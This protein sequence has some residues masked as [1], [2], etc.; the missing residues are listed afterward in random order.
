MEYN[1]CCQLLFDVLHMIDKQLP[2]HVISTPHVN[3][4][5][6]LSASN[7]YRRG[8]FAHCIPIIL[9]VKSAIRIDSVEPLI[10]GVPVHDAA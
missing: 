5:S 9:K 8:M 1:L 3:L 6:R 2:I 10:E 7:I 4:E